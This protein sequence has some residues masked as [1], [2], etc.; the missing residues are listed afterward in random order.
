MNKPVIILGGGIWG[1]L[2]AYKLKESLPDI[3]FTLYEES[4]IL[5]RHEVW[6]FRESDCLESISWLRPLISKTWYEHRINLNDFQKTY[7][8]PCHLI[9][10]HNL[11]KILLEKL[12]S[13]SLRLNN[14]I[15]LELAVQESSFV[16]V[17]RD[18]CHFKKCSYK[19]SLTMEVELQSNHGLSAPVLFDT[20]ISNDDSLRIFSYYP[21]S[22][23]VLLI[24]DSCF[25][26]DPS[27][28]FESRRSEL[29]RAILNLG[30]RVEK[31][32]KEEISTNVLPTSKPI[33]YQEGRVINLAGLS[34]D[35]TGC[36]IPH[37]TRLI[38]K[39]VNTSF[40][41]GEIKE[42]VSDFRNNIERDRN[43]LR[44]VNKLI[45]QKKSHHLM[46]FIYKEPQLLE[47]FSR[48]SLSFIDRSRILWE[49]HFH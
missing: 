8:G 17:T 10:G 28:S 25:S 30:W 12:P 9:D 4:S 38:E 44:Y 32:L 37:A 36:S 14:P 41:F 23:N 16:I 6:T 5:G 2:L 43:F 47:N 42:I 45:V 40:R 26:H 19:H 34:H 11:H 20:R 24:K 31:V 35:I 3:E 29:S 33:Y 21:L 49:H 27:M 1:C 46:E 13:R 22:P 39:I 48:G 15:T 18:V 7:H